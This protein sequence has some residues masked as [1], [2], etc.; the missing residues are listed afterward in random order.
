MSQCSDNIDDTKRARLILDDD[1]EEQPE[2]GLTKSD[3][4]GKQSG[5][6]R[7]QKEDFSTC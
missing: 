3:G 4:S 1:E 6:Q 5:E 2:I 7:L